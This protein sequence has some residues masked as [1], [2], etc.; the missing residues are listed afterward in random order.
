M[1]SRTSRAWARSPPV[2]SPLPMSN[3]ASPSHCSADVGSASKSAP[4]SPS[5]VFTN[6]CT[7]NRGTGAGLASPSGTHD[8][9]L[10]NPPYRL[11]DHQKVLTG[12][13][14]TTKMCLMVTRCNRDRS[15]RWGPVN[16]LVLDRAGISSRRYRLLDRLITRWQAPQLDREL[17][18]GA[19]PESRVSLALRAQFLVRPSERRRLARSLKRLVRDGQA[20]PRLP[21]KASVRA[22]AV[23]DAHSDLRA[24]IDRLVEVGPLDAQGVARVLVLLRD[25][26]G[27]L[28]R[29][30]RGRD[31]RRELAAAMSAFGPA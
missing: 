3:P 4:E 17:A 21:V 16:V 18:E 27:P 15:T 14:M 2:I 28:Y 26:A 30:G 5:H 31:L 23:L 13:C 20:A 1:L 7:S 12:H 11:G 19:Q 9:R 8:G 22:Q 25:G 29:S 10:I 24:L 6:D